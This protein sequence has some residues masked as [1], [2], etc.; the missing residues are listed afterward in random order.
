MTDEKAGAAV[1]ETAAPATLEVEAPTEPKPKR[2]SAPKKPTHVDY[3]GRQ[4]E[5]E[6]DFLGRTVD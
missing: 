3:M 5:P 2:K 4:S 1:N 6:R